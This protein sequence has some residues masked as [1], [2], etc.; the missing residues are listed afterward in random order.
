VSETSTTQRRPTFDDLY[1]VGPVL[2]LAA[3]ALFTRVAPSDYWFHIATARRV[4]LE[5]AVPTTDAFTFTRAGES[6]L[7]QPWLAQL[8]LYGLHRLGGLPLVITAHAA[9]LTGTY[10]LLL[11]LC[12]RLSGSRRAAALAVVLVAT[13]L[14]LANWALRPQAMA[15]PLFAVTLWALWRARTADATQA[16]AEAM[17]Q[18][19]VA[20]ES[21]PTG[22]ARRAARRRLW[23]LPPVM[24]LWVN[25]HGSFVLAFAL[26]GAFVLGELI[27]RRTT[28]RVGLPIGTVIPVAGATLVA[29]LANPAGVGV[30]RYVADLGANP[31][32][33][34]FVTE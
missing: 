3:I 27:S 28:G 13:P 6:Y 26:L 17:T 14:S 19:E 31:S 21:D 7:N 18:A 8:V 33:R 1:V 11:R 9:W 2:L 10:A 29:S 25:V 4:V 34:Y 20:V 24:L 22:S 32:V 5:G 12:R 15:Y 23:L 16:E 30:Y